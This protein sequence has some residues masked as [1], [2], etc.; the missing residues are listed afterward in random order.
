MCSTPLDKSAIKCP[1]CG[2]QMNTHENSRM[3]FVFCNNESCFGYFDANCANHNP[4][5]VKKIKSNGFWMVKKQCLNC[6]DSSGQFK[7]SICED[8][9][10]LPEYN[11]YLWDEYHAIL[12]DQRKKYMDA[13]AKRRRDHFFYEHNIYLNSEEWKAKRQMVLQRDN[14]MCQACLDSRAT[15]VHHLTY[16]HWQKEP[17]FELISVCEKC[18]NSITEDDRQRL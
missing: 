7:N 10:S 6:G 9:N 4:V 15:Q 16:K 8:I 13:Q 5:F 12:W 18:H 2:G 11:E 1:V 17:L 3:L 14:Y